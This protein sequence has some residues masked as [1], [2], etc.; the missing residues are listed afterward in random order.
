MKRFFSSLGIALTLL[1][2]IAGTAYLCWEQAEKEAQD[3]E[4]A[5]LRAHELN[6]IQ[7][8]IAVSN[9]FKAMQIE[10]Y[11][12]LLGG[13]LVQAIDNAKQEVKCIKKEAFLF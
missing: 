9:A 2:P 10:H 13:K 11:C 8:R 5:T 1:S 4:A 7:Q 12:D 3:K 6:A